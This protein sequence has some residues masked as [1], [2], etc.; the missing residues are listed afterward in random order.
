MKKLPINSFN[1]NYGPDRFDIMLSVFDQ[2]PVGL[3]CDIPEGKMLALKI[4]V[5]FLGANREEGEWET[6]TGRVHFVDPNFSNEVREYK[7]ST[8]HKDGVILARKENKDVP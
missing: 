8:R 4:K 1:V 2:K 7:Y 3:S 6:W 5:V